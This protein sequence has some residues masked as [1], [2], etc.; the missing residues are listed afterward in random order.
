MILFL[1]AE[2]DEATKLNAQDVEISIGTF[3]RRT[4]LPAEERDFQR[5]QTKRIGEEIPGRSAAVL[6]GLE[7]QVRRRN[8][9]VLPGMRVVD[10]LRLVRIGRFVDVAT[11][12]PAE[13]FRIPPYSRDASR[14]RDAMI[15]G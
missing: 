2:V 9:V 13:P 12:A 7:R 1:D 5:G 15:A 14:R 3:D 11:D 8:N 10:R 6:L 4:I